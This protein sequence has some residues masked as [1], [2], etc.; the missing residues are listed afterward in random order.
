MDTVETV[1]CHV[2]TYL[3]AGARGPVGGAD[4]PLHGGVR[5]TLLPPRHHGQRRIQVYRLDT[6]SQEQVR[7]EDTWLIWCR[8]TLSVIYDPVP[9]LALATP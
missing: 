1:F 9:G 8:R 2:V 7:G 4:L 6:A 5:G 3:V